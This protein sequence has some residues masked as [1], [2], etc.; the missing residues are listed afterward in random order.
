MTQPAMTSD[1]GVIL[2]VGI[3]CAYDRTAIVLP[4]AT[5]GT[6]HTASDLCKGAID[7]AEN[8]FLDNLNGIMCISAHIS[9]I[10]AEGMDDGTV[11]YR[12]DYGPGDHPG[13]IAGEAL[14]ANCGALLAFYEEPLDL[15]VGARMRV[16]KNAIAGIPESKFVN[17]SLIAAY[18]ADVQ[19]VGT[20]LVNGQAEGG[21]S[22]PTWYRVLARNPK[23]AGPG[24][25][26]KRVAISQARGYVGTQRRRLTPHGT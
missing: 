12:V 20:G 19:L 23:T 25:Q 2:T 10:Q 15:A 16:G 26:L 24:A 1:H 3:T 9:F 13:T 17:G 8:G 21:G 18:L 11:P 7:M 5:D 4:M 22:S 6:G 14:P